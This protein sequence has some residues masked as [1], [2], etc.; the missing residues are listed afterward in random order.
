[1]KS[2]RDLTRNDKVALG[3]V[4]QWKGKS[5]RDCTK[6]ELIDAILHLAS[7]VV[8]LQDTV[9]RATLPFYRRKD[10]LDRFYWRGWSWWGLVNT[11]TACIANRVVVRMVDKKDEKIFVQGYEW[12]KATDFPRSKT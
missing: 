6:G 9:E 8:F 4:M 3:Q 5:L 2:L 1:M 7:Q 10:W 11:L 12:R